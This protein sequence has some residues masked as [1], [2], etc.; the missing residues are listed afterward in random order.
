MQT[1]TW[2]VDSLNVSLD[3]TTKPTKNISTTGGYALIMDR[4]KSEEH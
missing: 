1:D 3:K 4:N 2:N